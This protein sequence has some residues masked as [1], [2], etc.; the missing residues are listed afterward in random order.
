LEEAWSRCKPEEPP[1]PVLTLK[2]KAPV[3]IST[4][5]QEDGDTIMSELM[6]DISQRAVKRVKAGKVRS[7]IV[8]LSEHEMPKEMREL[9][10]RRIEYRCMINRDANRARR[11]KYT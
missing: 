8:L 2:C 5:P 6:L 9:K 4:T 11:E 10:G 3:V 7:N 1:P